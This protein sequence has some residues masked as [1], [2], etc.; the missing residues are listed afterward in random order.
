MDPEQLTLS[1]QRFRSLFENNPDFVLFQDRAGVILDANPSALALLNNSKEEVAGRPFT[2]FLPVELHGLFN[3]KLE[4]AFHGHKVKFDAEVQFQGRAPISLSVTKVPLIVSSAVT[5]VHMVARDVTELFASHRIIQDQASRLNTVFESITDAFFL[6]DHDFRFTY[7]NTEVERLLGVTRAQA[8]NQPFDYV[9]R[10]DDDGGVFY[11]Q[12]RRAL[13]TRRAAHFEA[14]YQKTNRWLEVKA[15]PSEDQL[16]VYFADISDKVRSQEDMYRQH[17]DLQQFTYIVSHNLRAPLANALGLV[18]LLGSMPRE[19]A[20]YPPVLDNLRT[21][22]QQLDTVLRDVN[23]ILSVRDQQDV[24]APE[25]VPLADVVRQASQNLQEPLRQQSGELV[26]N[27][28]ESLHV[29]ATRA[30]LYSIFFNLLSNAMKYR[31]QSRRLRVE[32]SATAR[33][34]GGVDIVVADNGSGFDLERAGADVFRLY[35]RFHTGHPGRGVGLYLVKTHVEAMGGTVE[36]E[37]TVDVG[38]RFLIQL[39]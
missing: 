32:V 25:L 19:S 24:A 37:S 12:L 33:P 39:P 21:S 5:G 1:E 4:E 31:S 35:K 20:D 22:V 26:I 23:T 9:V 2:D 38:T 18:D 3:R 30:Y 27:I 34:E 14:Y 13:E 7:V 29:R 28:D 8:L 6:L 16:S 15:F 17:K 10:P 36:V 11:R